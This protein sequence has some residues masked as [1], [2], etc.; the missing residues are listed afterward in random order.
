[1]SEQERMKALEERLKSARERAEPEASGNG[2][3][4]AMGNVAWRMVVELVAG[5]V[6]G[7]GIGMGLDSLLGTTPIFLITFI[8]FG[9]AAGIN[10]MMRT[11]KEVREKQ[12]LAKETQA[13]DEETNDG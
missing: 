13:A 5:I 2:D 8:L 4:Y 11:A 1:M 3:H 10:V 12:A 7:F 6:I 9:L